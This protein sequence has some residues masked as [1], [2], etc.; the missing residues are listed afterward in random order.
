MKKHILTLLLMASALSGCDDWLEMETIGQKV[1]ENYITDL[2]SAVYAYNGVDK[3][4]INIWNEL[5]TTLEAMADDA[6]IPIVA[7]ASEIIPYDRLDIDYSTANGYYSTCYTGITRINTALPYIQQLEKEKER[8]N[9]VEGQMYFMR[10]FFY[11]TLV[12]LYG[13]VPVMPKINSVEDAKQPRADFNT[14]YG[15]IEEDLLKAVD[16]LPDELDGN[17]GQEIGKPYKYSAYALMA[18][19]YAYF[20]K[21]SKVNGI[22]D[23]ILSNKKLGKV[24]YESIFHWEDELK[25]T[26]YSPEYRKEILLDANFDEYGKQKFTWEFVPRGYQIGMEQGYHRGIIYTT[27]SAIDSKLTERPSRGKPGESLLELF[28]EGDKRLDYFWVDTYHETTGLTGNLKFYGTSIGYNAAYVNFP[29]YRYT[30]MLLLKAEA[31]NELGDFTSALTLINS[32]V[33]QPMGTCALQASDVNAVRKIIRD[34]R[35]RELCFESKRFFDLNR[36]G[37]MA[38]YLETQDNIVGKNITP[39]LVENPIT[40]KKNFVFALPLKEVNANPY[41]TENNPGY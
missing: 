41:I 27:T 15:N 16:L 11:F 5:P 36:W 8:V 30:E 35:R 20:E 31:L 19:F 14:L 13:E 7:D 33:R 2:R 34:E 12:R 26:D 24:A 23:K 1:E 22:V 9:V 32:K 10:A 17:L 28:E 40:G 38:E 21:W 3:T 25:G 39:H 6:F 29:V 37:I 4:F 18:D